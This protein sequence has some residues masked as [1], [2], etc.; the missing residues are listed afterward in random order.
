MQPGSLLVECLLEGSLG[1]PGD[2]G[3]AAYDA[4]AQSYAQTLP[5][6]SLKPAQVDAIVSQIELL[7]LFCDALAM[8]RN[9]DALRRTAQRLLDLAQLLQPGRPRRAPPPAM[10]RAAAKDAAPKDAAPTARRSPARKR[11]RKPT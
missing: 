9:D 2:A 10:A 5:E 4:L 6:V 3:Q 7:A 8:V 11:E 1:Q